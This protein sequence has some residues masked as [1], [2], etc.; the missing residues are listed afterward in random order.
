MIQGAGKISNHRI[1]RRAEGSDHVCRM[2]VANTAKKSSVITKRIGR[3][4]KNTASISAVFDLT[5][6][7]ASAI[8]PSQDPEHH[9]IPAVLGCSALAYRANQTGSRSPNLAPSVVE[10]EGLRPRTWAT[11]SNTWSARQRR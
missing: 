4:G 9:A 6:S 3:T 7:P 2:S 8:E 1:R 10:A 5:A 11:G